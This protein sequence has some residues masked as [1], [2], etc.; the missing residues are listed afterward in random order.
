MFTTRFAAFASPRLFR[1]PCRF[2]QFE[3]TPQTVTTQQSTTNFPKRN[4]SSK[5][6][7]DK[8]VLYDDVLTYKDR[9]DVLLID[10]RDP[11][12][13][14]ETGQI[15]AS[16]NIPLADLSNVLQNTS[17]ADFQSKYGRELPDKNAN[18]V[19]SC[20]MGGR[21]NKGME[22]ALKLGFTNA[23]FYKGSWLEWSTK[24]QS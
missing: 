17:A 24:Q 20:K 19:F 7:E 21:A 10:V 12:E 11:H 8:V 18:L 13:L 22:A 9:K 3:K 14:Q 23:K 5:M 2:I 1:L 6:A 4:F 16:I 15:P